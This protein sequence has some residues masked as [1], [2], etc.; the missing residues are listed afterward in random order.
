VT[1]N[2]TAALVCPGCGAPLATSD[3]LDAGSV[4][5]PELSV[6]QFRCPRCAAMAWARLGD[7]AIALGAAGGDPD[8]FA[9]AR[10]AGLSVRLDGGWL[11]CWF[12]SRYRR[13]P[14]RA[15]ARVA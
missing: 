1:E 9:A 6:L 2:L 12:A 3:V 11:D 5:I 10:E 15:A 8:R 14:A 13:Y 7:G 4:A